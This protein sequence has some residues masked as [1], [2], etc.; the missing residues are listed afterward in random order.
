MVDLEYLLSFIREDAPHGDVTSDIVIGDEFCHAAIISREPGIIAGI[1]ETETICRHFNITILTSVREGERVERGAILLRMSGRARDILLV[2]RTLL[3]IIGRMSGI[4]SL[5][6]RLAELVH[7]LDPSCR[8]ACTRKTAPGLRALDKKAVCIGG[9]DPHRFSLSDGVLIKDNHLAIIS[10]EEAVTRARRHSLF[11]KIEV[12]VENA[13]QAVRA[14]LAGADIILLDN[15]QPTAILQTLEDLA[16]LGLR[17]RVGI[18][19]SGG[20]TGE[21]L[22]MYA[23]LGADVISL[24]FLTHSVRNLDVT[25]EISP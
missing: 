5:T 11:R 24:G 25:L 8:I 23:G 22:A 21:N 9:G 7:S 13:E 12:E 3:N 18:E 17:D 2:E 15:M 16:R 4:A 10:I 14:A 1:E 19:L 20:I 6:N